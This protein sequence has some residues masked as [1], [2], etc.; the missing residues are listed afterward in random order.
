MRALITDH[1]S[2]IRKI[3]PIALYDLALRSMTRS[4]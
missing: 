1:E 3:T 2:S 4:A